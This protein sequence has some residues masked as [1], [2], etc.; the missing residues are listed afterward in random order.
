MT[1]AGFVS[2]A[3][4]QTAPSPCSRV[5]AAASLLL[6]GLL[7]EALPDLARGAHYVA[8]LAGAAALVSVGAGLALWGR[9][10]TLLSRHA[11]GLAAGAVVAGV[12]L[13]VLLGLPGL[14]EPDRAPSVGLGF[15]VAAA[16]V[17]LVFLAV[18]AL[19]RKPEPSPDRPYAL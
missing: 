4:E 18:D 8:V 14:P 7:L 5:T 10:P 17:V 1:P 9:R 11:S 15:A 13:Q 16:L 2:G 6:G 12:M 3:R 19:Q